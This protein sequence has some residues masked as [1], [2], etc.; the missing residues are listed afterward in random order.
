MKLRNYSLIAAL[1]II[2]VFNDSAMAFGKIDIATC[3]GVY[4]NST[5]DSANGIQ[6]CINKAGSESAIYFQPGFYTINS[7]INISNNNVTLYS[8]SRSSARL[9]FT[10]CGDLI[11][12]S[13]KQ[14]YNGG[15]KGLWL[16]G[17]QHCAQTALHFVDGSWFSVEDLQIRKFIDSTASSV[18]IQTNGREGFN[19]R[20]LRIEADYP[21]VIAKNPNHDY[22]DA[23]H[24]HFE[25]IYTSVGNVLH[26]HITLQDPAKSPVTVSN[27]TIDGQNA[28]TGG[29]GILK[30]V[31]MSPSLSV[32]NNLKIA[33]VRHEQMALGCDK[34]I[35][36][37]LK[38]DLQNLM[39][40][41]VTLQGPFPN[42]G[43]AINVNLVDGISVRNTTYYNNKTSFSSQATFIKAINAKFIQLENNSIYPY[44]KNIIAKDS[45]GNDL[46]W[47]SGPHSGKECCY[48]S[49]NGGWTKTPDSGIL[50][51]Q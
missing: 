48:Q 2:C 29:C 39:I 10:G 9:D 43:T 16:L 31:Q 30:W 3:P 32:S 46:V 36:I 35:N 19:V 12:F 47:K 26:W 1:F 27:M 7:T 23:D 20:N 17:D 8:D 11:N 51:Q 6:T 22:L 14:L 42:L 25:N 28:M 15:I 18:G 34:E 49:L 13:N 24:F 44:S 5:I 37:E 41:N 4:R 50:G 21:I 40:D 33:N 45:D 38:R